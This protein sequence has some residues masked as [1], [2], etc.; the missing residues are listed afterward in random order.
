[1]STATMDSFSAARAVMLIEI[2][3]VMVNTIAMI[4]LICLIIYS[5]FVCDKN[6]IDE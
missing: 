6:N 3:I 5:P 1:M 2:M 4:V